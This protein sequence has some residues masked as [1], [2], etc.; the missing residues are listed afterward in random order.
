MKEVAIATAKDKG[1]AAETAEKKAQEYEKA[2][3]LAE[4]RLTELDVNQRGPELKLVEAES[5]NLAQ[6]DEVAD[7]KAA[8]EAWEEKWYNNGF[9]D[10]ENFVEPIVHEA[11]QHGFEK[12]WMAALQAVELPNDSPLRLPK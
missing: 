6:A 2:R 10:V 1:K 9:A 5:L 11:Q 3:A 4:K 7:L 8:L 12:G